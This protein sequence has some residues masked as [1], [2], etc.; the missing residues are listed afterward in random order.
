M[1]MTSILIIG[2]GKTGSAF[3]DLLS[4]KSNIQI[5]GIIDKNE[6][7]PGKKLAKELKIPIGTDT[8]LNEFLDKKPDVIINTTGERNISDRLRAVVPAETEIISDGGAGLILDI[9][10]EAENA[11]EAFRAESRFR[12]AIE[13]AVLPGIVVYDNEGRHIY[14]NRGFS[15]IVGWTEDD[16]VGMKP[17]FA[18]WPPEDAEYNASAFE[19]MLKGKAGIGMIEL[20]LCRRSGERFYAMV[21]SAPYHGEKMDGWVSSI[22]DITELKKKEEKL[23]SSREQLRNLSSHIEMVRESEKAEIAR[24]VHDELG[25]PLTALKLELASLSRRLA[26]D[27]V[28][29]LERTGVM[30][31]II[32]TSIQAAKRICTEM[33]PWVL[34]DMG[35]A[36]A[37]KWQ[38]EEFGKRTGIQVEMVIDPPGF[39]LDRDLSTAVFRIFQEVLM[40]VER[41]AA[42]SKIKVVL[43]KQ[44]GKL[45]LDVSD[46][47]IGIPEERIYDH[48]SFGLISIRERSFAWGGEVEIRGRKQEGTTV[49]LNIPLRV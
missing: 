43:L 25:Q 24:R 23:N 3:L 6:G 32:D 5:I 29:L 33:R 16:L 20:R 8:N 36:E 17:P 15:R 9:L 44:R 30:K 35:I 40:N 7:A 18:Y 31:D 41:H 2:A 46:N 28:H 4:S 48:R 34:D 13:D 22:A 26:G 21:L 11:K 14:S 1:N 10:E 19:A 47:G 12:K 37:I 38:A 27:Q 39:Y 42:A 45:V 49:T